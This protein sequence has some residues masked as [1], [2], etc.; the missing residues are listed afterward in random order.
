MMDL[1]DDDGVAI[2]RGPQA[3]EVSKGWHI[4]PENQPD[5]G[6]DRRRKANLAKP[7]KRAAVHVPMAGQSYNPD[8]VDHKQVVV[9]VVK[10]LEERKAAHDKF[11]AEMALRTSAEYRGDLNTDKMWEE[12]V[13]EGLRHAPDSKRKIERVKKEKAKTATKKNAIELRR[14]K[15]A[16]KHHSRHPDRKSIAG[17]VDRIDDL[18][19][20]VDR[21]TRKS[22][23]RHL[24]RHKARVEGQQVLKYGR[25]QHTPLIP[26]VAPSTAA[27]G[28]LRHVKATDVSH[29]AL[30]RMKSLEERSLVPARMRHAFNKRTVLKSKGEVRVV[31]ENFGGLTE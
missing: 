26:D 10:K 29:P 25:Y 9:T 15:R 31:H 23:L 21:D 12:E 11:A 6:A 22:E 20:E 2:N 27:A 8:E 14:E 28:K 19:K 7:N 13:K 1:W 5:L 17:D 4:D 18:M 3:R 16:N 30:D 24:R